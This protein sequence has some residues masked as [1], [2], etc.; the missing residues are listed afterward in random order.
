MQ[1][2][3]MSGVIIITQPLIGSPIGTDINLVY[4]LFD[5]GSLVYRPSTGNFEVS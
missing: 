3:D 1:L 4:G 2:T 5:S